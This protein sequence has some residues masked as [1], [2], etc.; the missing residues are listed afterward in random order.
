MNSVILG[1][2]FFKKH[3]FS[4]DPKNNLLKLP[5]LTVQLN[6]IVPEKGKK[7]YTKELPK[8]P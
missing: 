6:Q 8:I 1:N 7:R 3:D 4:I 2:C 5:D